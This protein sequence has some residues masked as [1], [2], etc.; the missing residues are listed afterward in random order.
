MN[1]NADL[2]KEKLNIFPTG[3]KKQQ[4]NAQGKKGIFKYKTNRS[5]LIKET[6][7]E[8]NFFNTT[9]RCCFRF[10]QENKII[11][12]PSKRKKEE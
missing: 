6:W 12:K 5:S 7:N 11:Y 2:Q 1:W 8:I 4:L 9:L 10:Q 3:S